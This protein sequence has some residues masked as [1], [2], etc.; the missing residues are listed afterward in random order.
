MERKSGITQLFDQ[1]PV[2]LA[3][4]VT[5]MDLMLMQ[6]DSLLSSSPPSVNITTNPPT[7]HGSTAAAKVGK[8]YLM[9]I[10]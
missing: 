7:I 1:L 9:I 4:P 10:Y 5:D 2:H 6:T 3:N 8:D